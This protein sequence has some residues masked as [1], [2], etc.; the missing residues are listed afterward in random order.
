MQSRQLRNCQQAASI[1]SRPSVM[2]SPV[3]SATASRSPKFST[4]PSARRQRTDTQNLP[5]CRH[6]AEDRLKQKLQQTLVEPVTK[7]ALAFLL[8]ADGHLQVLV[9]D[10][11]SPA[12]R[13]LGAIHGK[14]GV[15]DQQV[16]R[17]VIRSGNG[18]ADAGSGLNDVSEDIEG[19]RHLRQNAVGDNFQIAGVRMFST[20]TA[21]S[22]PPSRAAESCG[23]KHR[24]SR[25]ATAMR[26]HRPRRGPGRR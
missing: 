9:E 19:P 25:S 16:G 14:V 24:R 12:A 17:G 13:L 5:A 20:S 6:E 8:A 3:S 23:R 26:T 4:E 7:F 2:E 18:R 15:A 10:F 21:N 22:S 1:V 11:V